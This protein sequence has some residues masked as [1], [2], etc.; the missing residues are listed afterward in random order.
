MDDNGDRLPGRSACLFVAKPSP[1]RQND[2]LLANLL[3]RFLRTRRKR[4]CA[5]AFQRGVLAN[6]AHEKIRG[7]KDLRQ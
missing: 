4:L 1:G 2:L 5:S 7:D 6:L 3:D